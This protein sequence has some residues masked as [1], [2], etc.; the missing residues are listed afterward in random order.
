M[1]LEEVGT[2]DKFRSAANRGGRVERERLRDRNMEGIQSHVVPKGQRK[3]KEQDK[4]KPAFLTC[5]FT[6]KNFDKGLHT[7]K[8]DDCK[9]R[10]D[11]FLRF[12]YKDCTAVPLMG[13]PDG[14][15]L[16]RKSPYF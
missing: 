1:V 12:T 11:A 9:V 3:D 5:T 2:T 14:L 8:E 16:G 7:S 6:Y 10:H 15:M 13:R 4:N